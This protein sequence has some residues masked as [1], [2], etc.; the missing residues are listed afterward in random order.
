MN[1]DNI[2]KLLHHELAICD[3][4]YAE[5]RDAWF[6]AINNRDE[7]GERCYADLRT[8]IAGEKLGI[9]NAIKIIE[10]N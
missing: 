6:K 4:L 10:E 8:Q 5:Y 7:V 1:K 2:I 3:K 9:R